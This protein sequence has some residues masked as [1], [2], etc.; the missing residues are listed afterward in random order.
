MRYCLVKG[1]SPHI[2]QQS[3]LCNQ[4]RTVCEDLSRSDRVSS[5]VHATCLSVGSG[6]K[7]RISCRGVRGQG[8]GQGLIVSVDCQVDA[9]KHHGIKTHMS[10]VSLVLRV[11]C[12]SG[13]LVWN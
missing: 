13:H 5:C 11:S 6:S 9:L 2:K 4:K 7:S 12:L 8:Q 1:K 10:I 3:F